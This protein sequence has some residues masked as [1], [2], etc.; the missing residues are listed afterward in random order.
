M[1][2]INTHEAKTR[3]S[4]ILSRIEQDGEC[5][6]VCRTGKPIADLIPHRRAARTTL[7]PVMNKVVLKYD[8]V[9]GVTD[10]EWPEES[11]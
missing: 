6:V 10:D 5:A 11:R 2:T 7:H 9:E 3:L 1:I 4:A 8:P